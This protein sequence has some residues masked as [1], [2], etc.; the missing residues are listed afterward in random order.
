M[1]AKTCMSTV[2]DYGL[3]DGSLILC[4]PRNSV[5]HN[6]QIGSE[7]RPNPN[8]RIQEW[9]ENVADSSPTSSTDVKSG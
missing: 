3:E 7:N 5:S 8:Q 6:V 4:N 2:I 1:K 9:P